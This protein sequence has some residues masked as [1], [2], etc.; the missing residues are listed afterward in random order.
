VPSVDTSATLGLVPS[1]D[2]SA[3]LGLVLS[4]DTSATLGLVPSIETSATLG[5]ATLV[6]VS[7]NSS[8]CARFP[9]TRCICARFIR[10]LDVKP[11]P[12]AFG[13]DLLSSFVCTVVDWASATLGLVPSVDT[14]AT[15]GLVPSVD[16]SATLGLVPFV[17]TSATLGLEPSGHCT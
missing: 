7:F 2:T 1:V 13:P 12:F 4:V 3:T 17:D 10:S 16:T 9:S 5:L 14:S 8:G 6:S 15:L 11:S